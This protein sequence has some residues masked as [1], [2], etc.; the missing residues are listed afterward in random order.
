VSALIFTV[1]SLGMALSSSLPVFLFMRFAAGIGVGMAS[2]L[3]PMYIAEISPAAIRGRNVSINQLTIVTGILVT[4]LVNYTLADN[5]NEA[6]RWMFGLGCIPSLVFFFGV[7]WL[8]ESPRWLVKANRPD[9]AQ[10]VLSKIGNDDFAQSTMK[11]IEFSLRGAVKQSYGAV[12]QKSVRPAVLVGITFAVFQQLCGIN[13]VFNY[14]STIFES[15]G[16]NLD[17]QLLET[18]S[19]GAA[20]LLFTLL[21]MW[22]I[23][24]LGRRPQLKKNILTLKFSPF[25]TGLM[26]EI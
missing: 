20:N 6:W 13:V 4:N 24:K 18:V 8:P 3:S 11:D 12:F 21:A 7:L 26:L 17:R 9:E 19:I 25:I 22:Q 23:D 14:T 2:M 15:V 16:A 1:S 5:G 10:K